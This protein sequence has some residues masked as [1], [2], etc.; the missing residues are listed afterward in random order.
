M[1]EAVKHRLIGGA[2]L[3]AIGVL[4]IPSFFKDKQHYQVDTHSQIP[5]RP[6]ITAVE[7]SD[8]EQVQGIEP[9]PS[10]DTMFVPEV[11]GS[12]QPVLNDAADVLD[13][14]SV[15]SQAVKSSDES[16]RP[17]S[18]LP[19]TADGIPES[20]VIQVAS[21]SAKSSALKLR[22]QLQ[23][24]GYRAYIR[25]VKTASAEVHRIFIGPNLSKADAQKLKSE[26]DKQLKVNSII[27]PFKP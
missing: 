10:P 2:I 22:D 7:F 14:A 17:V 15:S 19:L 20:W 4:F 27:L 21:L 23:A 25:S 16:V 8:P 13:G 11:V 5:A 6:L 3:V 18:T 26:L 12:E 24:E 9:A 1:K